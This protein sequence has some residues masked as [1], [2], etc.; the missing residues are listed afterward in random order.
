MNM[1]FGMNQLTRLCVFLSDGLNIWT[2]IDENKIGINYRVLEEEFADSGLNLDDEVR[3]CRVRGVMRVVSAA[4]LLFP[5]K[6]PYSRYFGDALLP[7]C[8]GMNEHACV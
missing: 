6:N 8:T 3:N 1:T 5:L 7:A 2:T 4:I